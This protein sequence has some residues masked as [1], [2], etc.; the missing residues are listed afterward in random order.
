MTGHRPKPDVRDDLD[1]RKNEEQQT[2]GTDV[3][4]NEKEVRHNRQHKK[5][6]WPADP[7]GHEKPLRQEKRKAALHRFPWFS[8]K[9]SDTT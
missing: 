4:H 2:K 3:T 7:G 6:D 5:D 8:I 1:S 9:C